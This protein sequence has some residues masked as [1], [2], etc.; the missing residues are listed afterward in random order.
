MTKV[1]PSSKFH[2]LGRVT[3]RG[4]AQYKQT[5]TIRISTTE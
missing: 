1:E 2:A 3:A 4:A 5:K